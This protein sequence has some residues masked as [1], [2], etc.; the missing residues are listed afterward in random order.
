MMNSA[1]VAAAGLGTRL[2]S[3]TKEQPKE[4]LPVFASTDGI[5][6]VKPIIQEIFEQ[7]FDVGVR[8]FFF[9]V[10]KGK[11]AIEDHFTPDREFID[12]LGVHGNNNQASHLDA[13]YRRIDASMIVWVNQ[14]EPKGFGDAVLQAKH[15]MTEEPFLLHAGDTIIKSRTESIPTRLAQ[16]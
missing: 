16:A 3:A 1:V 12:R 14:P 10:G 9:I 8:R 2:L 7:L 13:F 5:V 4:M 11:R 15:L 6:C